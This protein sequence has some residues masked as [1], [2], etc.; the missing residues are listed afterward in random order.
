MPVRSSS[1]VSVSESGCGVGSAVGRGVGSLVGSGVSAGSAG[2][3]CSDADA[4]AA[5]AAL[6]AG[7]DSLHSQNADY[8]GWLTVG[9]T[10]IDYPVMWTPSEPEY[11]LRRASCSHVTA[12]L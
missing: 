7:Y 3:V 1:P 12:F 4:A 6:A 8:A 10:A 5:A 2:G 11:Y 9:G